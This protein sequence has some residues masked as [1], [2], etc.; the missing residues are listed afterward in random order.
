MTITQ[1][2]HNLLQQLTNNRIDCLTRPIIFVAHSLG[3]ILV[4]DTIIQSA[5]YENHLKCLS[6]SCSAIFFFGTPHRGSSAARYGEI[7]SNIV[8]ALPGGFSLYKEILRG[9]KPNGE[10]LS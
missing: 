3:G 6:Q 9:L 5:Q 7:L 4:K 8:G 2:A 1:H 10:K